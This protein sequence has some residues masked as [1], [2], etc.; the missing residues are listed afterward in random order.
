M[1][2]VG[3]NLPTVSPTPEVSGGAGCIRVGTYPVGL[4]FDPT[5]STRF[6]SDASAHNV[7]GRAT[8]N[9]GADAM[10]SFRR[11]YVGGSNGA[12]YRTEHDQGRVEGER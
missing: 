4:D 6:V 8:Q 9:E 7:S 1:P 5:T 3:A 12:P 2:T 10:R 11:A